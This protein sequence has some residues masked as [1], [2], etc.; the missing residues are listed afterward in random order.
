M[1]SI[2]Q[3]KPVLLVLLDLSDAFYTIDHSVP[4]SSLKDTFDKVLDLL[5]SYLEQH[6]QWVTVRGMFS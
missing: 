3:G 6:V 2:D 4:F 5:Q 1:M